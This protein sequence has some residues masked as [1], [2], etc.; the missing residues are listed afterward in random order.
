MLAACVWECRLGQLDY[1]LVFKVFLLLLDYIRRF[2]L[3]SFS[4]F[5]FRFLSVFETGDFY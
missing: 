2:G 5:D 1:S 4:F 3:G